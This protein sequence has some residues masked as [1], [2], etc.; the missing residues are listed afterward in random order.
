MSL[1]D[2]DKQS[3]N[4]KHVLQFIEDP[5][6]TY[7]DKAGKRYKLNPD[8]K[9]SRDERYSINCAT[10]S[11]A[12]ALRLRGFNVTAKGCVERSGSRNEWAM[13]GHSFDMWTNA[14]GTP[15]KP[16][17][18]YEWKEKKGYK[19]MTEKRYHEYFEEVTKE[20]GV[21]ILTIGWKGRGGHATI[22]QRFADGTL[23]YIEPQEYNG[24]AAKRDI[25]ELCKKGAG[26]PHPKRGVLRVDNKIFNAGYMDLFDTE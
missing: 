12:Y 17:Y 20:E 16:A 6:G 8:Y 2:A 24:T 21:Y 13:N 23:A 14:D 15:A 5:N 26:N 9:K 25:D 18:T 22:L 1:D 19:T 7:R 3:A 4:P 10:C 11:P